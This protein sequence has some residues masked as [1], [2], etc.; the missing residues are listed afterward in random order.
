MFKKR[1]W[2]V[3]VASLLIMSTVIATSC[4]KAEQPAPPAAAT[5]KPSP[6]TPPATL[7]KT[8]K[9]ITV[10]EFIERALKNE[11]RRG[12]IV[13]VSG[14]FITRQHEIGSRGDVQII[15]LDLLTLGHV[16]KVYSSP[17]IN[18]RKDNLDRYASFDNLKDRERIIVHGSYDGTTRGKDDDWRFMVID[19]A[20]IVR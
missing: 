15:T 18:P 9:A 7:P 6:S 13:L 4:A 5:T 19:Q 12:D 17:R 16:V 3:M 14:T 2:V 11:Y 8:E 1:I 10:S 20:V